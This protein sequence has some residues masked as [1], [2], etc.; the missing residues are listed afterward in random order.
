MPKFLY[1]P[2][3]PYAVNQAFGLNPQ[4][5]GQFGLKGHNGLDLRAFHGQPVYAAHDGTAYFESDNSGGEGVV[6]VSDEQIPY[7]ASKVEFSLD[8]TQRKVNYKTIYWHLCDEQKD[9]KYVCPVLLYQRKN[10]VGMPVKAGDLIGYADNTGFSTGDHLH[11]GL[12]PVVSGPNTP[13]DGTDDSHYQNVS[14]N[15]GYLGAID[16]APYLTTIPAQNVPQIIIT[17]KKVVPLLQQIL[18]LLWSKITMTK[19]LNIGSPAMPISMTGVGGGVMAIEFVLHFFGFD[20]QPG[21]VEAAVNGIISV[22]ALLTFLYGQWRRGDVKLFFF[23]KP[24]Q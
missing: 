12:K 23:K 11:F 4:T 20:Y 7:D 19:Q 18:D 16:P 2:I 10:K 8:Q 22:V 6:I 17:E 9:P 21:S 14:Q 15:N 24:Q 3:Q 1:Y 5:Y 13:V